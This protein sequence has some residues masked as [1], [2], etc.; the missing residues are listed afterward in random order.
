MF[1]LTSLFLPVKFNIETKIL[2]LITENH[3]TPYVEYFGQKIFAIFLLSDQKCRE[4][5]LAC[6]WVPI[7]LYAY[8]FALL[9]TVARWRHQLYMQRHNKGVCSNPVDYQLVCNFA[10]KFV[11]MFVC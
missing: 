8:C 4:I 10:T 2:G 7:D 9:E 11:T 6:G 3:A 5:V 1:P